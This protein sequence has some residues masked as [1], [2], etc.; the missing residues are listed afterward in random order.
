MEYLILFAC[1]KKGKIV[2]K[3][4]QKAVHLCSIASAFHDLEVTVGLLTFSLEGIEL[5]RN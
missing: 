5:E 3:N 2:E 1:Y 4:F